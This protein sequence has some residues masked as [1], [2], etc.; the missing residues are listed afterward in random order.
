MGFFDDV[1]DYLWNVQK[2][3]A[4]SR[5]HTTVPKTHLDPSARYYQSNWDPDFS[6]PAE[7]KVRLTL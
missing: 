1:P 4:L 3:I 6:C 7:E 5:Q 2:R